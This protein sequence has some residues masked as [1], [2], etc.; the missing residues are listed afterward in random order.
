M[1]GLRPPLKKLVSY[2]AGGQN[3]GQSG[4]CKILLFYVFVFFLLFF[5][6]FFIVFF[7]FFPFSIYLWV[8]FVVFFVPF[9]FFSFSLTQMIFLTERKKLKKKVADGSNDILTRP[10]HRKLAF[11]RMA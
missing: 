7:S 5:I 4:D 6:S 10:L 2:P 9:F 1:G 8:L 3:Y 11:L